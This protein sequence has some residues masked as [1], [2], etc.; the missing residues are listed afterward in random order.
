MQT[1]DT[2]HPVGLRNWRTISGTGTQGRL[3]HP[4]RLGRL[5]TPSSSSGRG[6]VYGERWGSAGQAHALP[7][8]LREQVHHLLQAPSITSLPSI[9][10]RALTVTDLSISPL[11]EVFTEPFA[12]G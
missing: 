6:D 7:G 8:D 10:C 2:T 1:G 12:K 11:S 3:E 4:V 9:L 5:G